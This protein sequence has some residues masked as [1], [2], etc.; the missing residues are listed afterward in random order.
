MPVGIDV[1]KLHSF[2]PAISVAALYR[3]FQFDCS[4]GA[5]PGVSFYRT[6]LSF[7][8]DYS[9]FVSRKFHFSTPFLLLDCSFYLYCVS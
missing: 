4:F 5:L 8:A 1:R 7:S 9:D 3:E 2:C 6:N